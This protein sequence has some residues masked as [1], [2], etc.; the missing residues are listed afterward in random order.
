ML[1]CETKI[2]PLLEKKKS[3]CYLL[4]YIIPEI[5]KAKQNKKNSMYCYINAILKKLNILIITCRHFKEY[6]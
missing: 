4:G 5:I 2:R 1:N 6:N 3:D